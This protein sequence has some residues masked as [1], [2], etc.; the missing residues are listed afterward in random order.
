M[1]RKLNAAQTCF[2]TE[3]LNLA[4]KWRQQS[5]HILSFIVYIFPLFQFEYYFMYFNT[6]SLQ[7]LMLFCVRRILKIPATWRSPRW[8]TERCRHPTASNCRCRS[9]F[10]IRRRR[11]CRRWRRNHKRHLLEVLIPPRV[12]LLRN[13]PGPSR[14]NSNRCVR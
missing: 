12:A 4:P 1:Q 10:R 11:F 8:T 5:T 14:S 7:K 9:R 6:D 2:T 13:T 3:I